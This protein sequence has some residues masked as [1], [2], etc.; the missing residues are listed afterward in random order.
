MHVQIIN[1]EE[2]FEFI[3][4]HK[5]HSETRIKYNGNNI[6]SIKGPGTNSELTLRGE[7]AFLGLNFPV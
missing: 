1:D 2:I 6:L 7:D 4:R 5:D 3:I